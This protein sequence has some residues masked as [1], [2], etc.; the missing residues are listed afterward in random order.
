MHSLTH[1]LTHF[2]VNYLKIQII[3]CNMHLPILFSYILETK[4]TKKCPKIFI[5]LDEVKISLINTQYAIFLT[6]QYLNVL[7]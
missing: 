4:P 7:F 1:I 3:C 2:Q 5:C 6:R